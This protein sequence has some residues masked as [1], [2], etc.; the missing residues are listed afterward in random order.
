[1]NEMKEAAM[2]D[3]IKVRVKVTLNGMH[4]PMH[5][6]G[7]TVDFA[8]EATNVNAEKFFD[9][10]TASVAFLLSEL[11]GDGGDGGDDDPEPEP[12]PVVPDHIPEDMLT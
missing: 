4:F 10:A 3:K 7:Q 5:S 1:M 8:A 9:E 6:H 12:D 11:R 2:A